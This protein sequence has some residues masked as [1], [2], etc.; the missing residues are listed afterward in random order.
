MLM[1]ITINDEAPKG[2][3]FGAFYVIHKTLIRVATYLLIPWS[4]T[5]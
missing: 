5:Q 3:N 1:L 4:T 2:E